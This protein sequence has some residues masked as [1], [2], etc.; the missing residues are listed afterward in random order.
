VTLAEFTPLSFISPR[1][2]L[3]DIVASIFPACGSLSILPAGI[4]GITVRLKNTRVES[5]GYGVS[6]L[7]RRDA[8]ARKVGLASGNERLCARR[9]FIRD[10]VKMQ[11]VCKLALSH[12]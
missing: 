9:V 3:M 6:H 5:S 8:T 1:D 2:R 12:G 7:E 4:E 10:A 11:A